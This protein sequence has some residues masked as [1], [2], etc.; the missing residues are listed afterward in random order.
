MLCART[1]ALW[2]A[3]SCDAQGSFSGISDRPQCSL[4][5]ENERRVFLIGKNDAIEGVYQS[6]SLRSLAKKKS[7]WRTYA[8][9][10][11]KP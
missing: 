4:T 1:I 8:N 3:N 7:S 2:T 9:L 5:R 11:E 6:T 10:G